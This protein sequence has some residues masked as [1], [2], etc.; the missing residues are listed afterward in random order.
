MKTPPATES[1]AQILFLHTCD[2][3]YGS[4][5]L[6]LDI[7]KRLDRSK[8]EPIVVLPDDMKHV[9]L[10]SRELKAASIEH[11]HLPTLVL[12]RR[13]ISPW[14]FFSLM[15]RIFFGNWALLRL[16]RRKQIKLIHSTTSAVLAG[17]MI[18]F[19]TGTPLVVHIQ[20]ILLRP[21]LIR[22]WIHAIIRHTARK[23]ICISDSV[24]D[25]FLKDQ[26]DA[27]GI[28]QVVRNCIPLPAS[29]NRTAQEIRNELGIDVKVP[30][31]GMV[32]RV[33]PWKGQE[34]LV[35]AA[36]IIRSKGIHCRFVAIGGVFH[37]ERTHL[38][39]LDRIRRLIQSLDLEE[40]VK[41]VE[42]R[43]DARELIAAFDIFVL[44]ST[45][46]EPFGLVILEAMAV[47]KPVIATAQG[48]PTEIVLEGETGVLIPPAD[49]QALAV[50]IQALLENPVE[51]RRLGEAGRKRML[52]QFEMSQYLQQIEEVYADLLNPT[53]ERVY[54][55]VGF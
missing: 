29:P 32:A 33:A 21:Q 43:K 9:G 52:E 51:A 40:M 7:V 5:I 8:F 42:Y 38:D 54:E 48:G 23:I 35:Q 18:A 39:H 4:D 3:L 14:A 1:P 46:P 53:G 28:T 6:I 2:D 50:A 27:A 47:G 24:R 55:R 36:A 45:Q 16:L 34:V 10:L 19:L 25:H 17:P 22:R 31:I 11:Y 30:V 15:K 44:P 49:P 12:R 20:E 37:N 13:Y 41:I 26:P